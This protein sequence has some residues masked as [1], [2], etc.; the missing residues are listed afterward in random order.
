MFAE[1]VRRVV[2]KLKQKVCH[3]VVLFFVFSFLGLLIFFIVM[4]TDPGP[5]CLSLT[6][7]FVLSKFFLVKVKFSANDAIYLIVHSHSFWVLE[8][9]LNS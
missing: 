9:T 8:G 2:R 1:I 4:A 3:F 6:F 5:K 7:S